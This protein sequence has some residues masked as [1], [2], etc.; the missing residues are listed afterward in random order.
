VKTLIR[1][2]AL[3]TFLFSSTASAQVG[4][5]WYCNGTLD[6]TQAIKFVGGCS[7]SPAT[8]TVT[9][10]SGSVT[11][12]APDAL[13]NLTFTPNPITTT[14][15]IGLNLAAADTWTGLHTFS[16]AK[17]GVASGSPSGTA[18]G[19]SF[20]G[21]GGVGGNTATPIVLNVTPTFNLTSTGGANTTGYTAILVN[22]T[23]TNIGTAA[24]KLIDLEV[25]SASKFYVT[26]TGSWFSPLIDSGI[27]QAGV[28]VLAANTF[29]AG[30]AGTG[31]LA[32]N[33]M[34]G[35]TTMPTGDFT[36]AG[37]GGKAAT[38]T[39]GAGG[40]VTITADNSSV[41]STSSGNLTLDAAATLNVGTSNSTLVQ[42]ARNG[43]QTAI[44]GGLTNQFHSISDANYTADSGGAS[45]YYIVESTMT[46]GRTVTLPNPAAGNAGRTFVVCNGSGS[47]QQLTIA[48][49][50]IQ[51]AATFAL[52]ATASY[53]CITLFSAGNTWL[54]ASTH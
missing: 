2:L 50:S 3:L 28:V 45:D 49:S 53:A 4:T 36:W 21:D 1:L 8:M 24:K 44:S 11:S 39:A 26:N 6:P 17:T 47:M 32:L 15:T 14:G 42:V 54:V 51:G 38:I 43:G 23:E 33:S 52:P 20:T 10:G 27:T 18:F 30:A 22:A 35:S 5:Q 9:V 37:A 31:G 34:T 40:M 12:I 25:G 41:W 7:Y 13:N 29:L 16:Q 19:P 48:S 46:A